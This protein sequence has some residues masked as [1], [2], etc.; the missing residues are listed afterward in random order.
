MGSI[1][2]RSLQ[3][4]A[5]A[6]LP[7]NVSALPGG[8]GVGGASHGLSLDSEEIPKVKNLIEQHKDSDDYLA[9]YEV[10]FAGT[11]SE[12]FES[13]ILRFIFLIF[14]LNSK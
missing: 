12:V 8:G 11:E 14:S 5:L 4:V 7:F 9:I 2:S 3:V 13:F 1:I 10:A 6:T